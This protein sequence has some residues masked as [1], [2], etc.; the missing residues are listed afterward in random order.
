MW[1]VA[2]VSYGKLR[3]KMCERAEPAQQVR[4]LYSVATSQWGKL[5]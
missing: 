2:R 3:R 1:G 5:L 4:N